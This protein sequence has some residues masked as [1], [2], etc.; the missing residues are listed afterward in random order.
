[1][2]VAEALSKEGMGVNPVAAF[3]HDHLFF[4]D[5]PQSLVHEPDH[6]ALDGD[7]L[8]NRVPYIRHLF[9]GQR[10]ILALVHT[11]DEVLHPV[12]HL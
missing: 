6:L 11:H 5:L 10:H 2:S 3:F 1:M 9:R 7:V 4:L 12:V 8:F